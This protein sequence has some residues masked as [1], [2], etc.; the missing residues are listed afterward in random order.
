MEARLRNALL[1][2]QCAAPA[3]KVIAMVS[4]SRQLPHAVLDASA[5][6]GSSPESALVRRALLRA[7]RPADIERILRMR[8]DEE[9]VGG[10][11]DAGEVL[12]T[13]LGCLASDTDIAANL[14]F[15][16]PALA[17]VIAD[18]AAS[19]QRQEASLRLVRCIAGCGA[20]PKSSVPTVVGAL[21]TVIR[22]AHQHDVE[23]E[24]EGTSESSIICLA[25]AALRD[26]WCLR[27][28]T[29]LA[30]V[31]PS[32]AHS[33]RVGNSNAKADGYST[34][35]ATVW[36]DVITALAF[37]YGRPRRRTR[38]AV[39][40]RDALCE[41]LIAAPR[42]LNTDLSSSRGHGSAASA[43][44]LQLPLDAAKA[45]RTGITRD[46]AAGSDSAPLA[47][48]AQSL[49]CHSR[50]RAAWTSA[51]GLAVVAARA[52]PGSEWFI[53]DEPL[54][55]TAVAS[56]PAGS[57]SGDRGGFLALLL[58]AAGVD[59][60]V[61]LDDLEEA[62]VASSATGGV[63]G[64]GVAAARARYAGSSTVG[65]APAPSMA[66]RRG[67][68]SAPT[69]MTADGEANDALR[70]PPRQTAASV[71]PRT[72]AQ[73]AALAAARYNDATASLDLD[74]CLFATL[75]AWLASRVDSVDVDVAVGGT[76]SRPPLSAGVLLSLQQVLNETVAVALAFLSATWHSNVRIALQPLLDAA[77]WTPVCLES[78]ATIAAAF[79]HHDSDDEA[80]SLSLR[81]RLVLW[82]CASS[83]SMAAAYLRDDPEACGQVV[84]DALPLLLRLPPP[85]STQSG[86]R[87]VVASAAVATS[88]SDAAR[89]P[90][91]T[92]FRAP[93]V[94]MLPLLEFAIAERATQTRD[95]SYAAATPARVRGQ[96]PLASDALHEQDVN[97]DDG[98]DDGAENDECSTWRTAALESGAVPLLLRWI[99]TA[100]QVV[101]ASVARAETVTAAQHG[102]D[103]TLEIRA[104][105]DATAMAARIV[106]V[107]VSTR[108]AVEA[109]T[110]GDAAADLV[111]L[112][113]C[114][115][116]SVSLLQRVAA[117][118]AGDDNE[119][120][121]LASILR[122][123]QAMETM[124]RLV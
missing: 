110:D 54:T 68:S 24:K 82:I 75:S 35:H 73:R 5:M 71:A 42:D 65:H 116:A 74:F 4:L 94:Q 51:I 8:G 59:I 67:E 38:G 101:C 16:A 89:S 13:F 104:M 97:D 47:T 106:A 36:A 119:E 61:A 22:H 39:A 72:R 41:C 64:V 100:A 23:A 18:T 27:P 9:L 114:R 80:A 115:A 98:D 49:A 70:P 2:I 34:P 105:C 40:A 121:L 10:S 99:A 48:D 78:Y 20:L 120:S 95:G 7:L 21:T 56:A 50:S 79:A 37:A 30:P 60:K 58:R 92:I 77:R 3:D 91:V 93:L 122:L 17:Y 31:H 109:A 29:I 96:R 1:L 6:G 107:L 117:T 45:L 63:E 66:P 14:G 26:V 124:L 103:A 43:S 25:I 52:L 46:I 15:L 11:F 123:A 53:D 28:T 102:D 118:G 32:K 12:L 88:L 55:S 112:S 33:V 108:R 44:P 84:R 113:T 81:A 57:S 19:V 90:G 62:L 76:A 86:V 83:A 69:G 111:T 87:P 85:E